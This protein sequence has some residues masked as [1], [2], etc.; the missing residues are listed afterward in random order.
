M[1]V[2]QP[3]ARADESKM[4]I[5]A[6]RTAK[7]LDDWLFTPRGER[8]GYIQPHGL[9]ELWFHTGTACNLACPFCLE[10]SKPGDRRL[11]R[12]SFAD[13]RPFI[14]EAIVLGVAQLSFTGG[15]PFIVKDFVRI[16]EY[17]LDRAPCLVLTNGVDAVTKRL[18]KLV[19][20]TR[21]THALAL[22]V[23]IDYPDRDR[24]DAG[25]GAGNFAKAWGALK[26]LH[27][28]GFR[29]SI[30]RQME[31]GEDTAAVDEAYRALGRSQGLPPDIRIV[32]FPDF[33]TPG[34][35]AEVPFV[36]ESC[37][38]TY[39]TEATRREFMCAYSKMVVKRE[40]RM[41]VYACTLVDDDPAYDQGGSLTESLGRRVMMRHHRC[42]S[43]FKFGASCSETKGH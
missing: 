21:K 38:T 35:H 34:S 16:L 39:H 22:R 13:V 1:V 43:C 17:A 23:S 18:G 8:R 6:P 33:G 9:R 37:M 40:G 2:R 26:L 3:T 7:P 4:S 41:R 10:G 14:D 31:L 20:L 42:F 27:E 32:S 24:H 12:V 36:T 5:E 11:D 28:A 25:R 19:P 29:V 15:E 30:A